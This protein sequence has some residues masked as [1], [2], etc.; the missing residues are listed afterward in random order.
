MIGFKLEGYV[1]T[2]IKGALDHQ[3]VLD[4][5]KHPDFYKLKRRF[6]QQLRVEHPFL[7]VVT[8]L[9]RMGSK[10]AGIFSAWGLTMLGPT[11]RTPEER[12]PETA[13]VAEASPRQ[14]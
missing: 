10:M 1:L 12:A 4:A 7:N 8:G 9:A 5:P 6:D 3:A 14:C 2:M 13:S 11:S